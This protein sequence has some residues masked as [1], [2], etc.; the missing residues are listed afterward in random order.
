M[1]LLPHKSQFFKKLS[2]EIAYGADG[3]YVPMQQL[4]EQPSLVVG[5]E[6]K[7]YQVSTMTRGHP[8]SV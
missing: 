8:T 3:A 1:P 7:D 6:M 4:Q 5:G 2:D